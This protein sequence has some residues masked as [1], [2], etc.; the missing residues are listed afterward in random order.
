MTHAPGLKTE[1]TFW[2]EELCE[3]K[4]LKG[5]YKDGPLWLIRSHFGFPLTSHEVLRLTL[6]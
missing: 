5:E 2:T 6:T 1:P 4:T 3:P